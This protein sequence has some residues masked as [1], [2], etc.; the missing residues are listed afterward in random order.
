MAKYDIF[1]ISFQP[2]EQLLHQ[3][4]RRHR[5]AC[6]AARRQH[7][8]S[9][10]RRRQRV[11]QTSQTDGVVQADI[12]RRDALHAGREVRAGPV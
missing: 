10:E 11:V 3:R 9:H 1:K 2:H 5:D 8:Q 4:L 12:G 6:P 7:R